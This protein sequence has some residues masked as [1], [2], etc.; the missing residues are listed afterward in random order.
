MNSSHLDHLQGTE[1]L[2]CDW[3]ACLQPP[4]A[5]AY[6]HLRHT[7]WW[8]FKRLLKSEM[9]H[10]C[11]VWRPHPIRRECQ[12]CLWE[13]DGFWGG[14][15]S[16]LLWSDMSG[17]ATFSKLFVRLICKINF[18]IARFLWPGRI[19]KRKHKR[20]LFGP[21]GGWVAEM[22]QR[23]KSFTSFE[24][25]SNVTFWQNFSCQVHFAALHL[26]FHLREVLKWSQAFS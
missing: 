3:V 13:R 18:S 26:R 2:P 16:D 22:C 20:L 8:G 14:L 11:Q 10:I 17:E 23:W 7:G 25:L 6:T 12:F 9:I 19:R 21:R 4:Q 15:P 5:P 1:L 24:N